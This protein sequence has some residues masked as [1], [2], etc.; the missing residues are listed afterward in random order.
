MDE[1]ESLIARLREDGQRV[2]VAGPQPEHPG[3]LPG[4]IGLK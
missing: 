4:T 1:V 3:P 2:W